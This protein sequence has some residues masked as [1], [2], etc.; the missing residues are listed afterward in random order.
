MA[1]SEMRRPDPHLDQYEPVRSAGNGSARSEQFAPPSYHQRRA[2]IENPNQAN[3]PVSASQPHRYTTSNYIEEEATPPKQPAPSRNGRTIPQLRVENGTP[4]RGNGSTAL[5]SGHHRISQIVAQ[6]SGQG[7]QEQTGPQRNSWYTNGFNGSPGRPKS[8][9]GPW[10]LGRTIGRGSTS[11]VRLVRHVR[12]GLQG[13]AKIIVKSFADS[14]EAQSLTNLQR[15]RD[16]EK[17]TVARAKAMPYGL[18]REIVI[19]KLLRHPNIVQLYDVW[20]NRNE[21]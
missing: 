14:A 13:A 6:E 17:R 12:T 3:V 4:A 1:P 20:E 18:E 8:T 21:L 15:I 19:M 11:R 5:S 16:S 2:L 9:I 7:S 10:Q